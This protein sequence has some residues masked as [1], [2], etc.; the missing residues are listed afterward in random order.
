MH[1]IPDPVSVNWK[2]FTPPSQRKRNMANK[3][4]PK[5]PQSTDSSDS[6]ES[7]SSDSEAEPEAKASGTTPA[8]LLKPTQVGADL[9]PPPGKQVPFGPPGPVLI[10]PGVSELEKE[11]GSVV[12][13]PTASTSADVVEALVAGPVDTSVTT[14]SPAPPTDTAPVTT[15]GS[16][17]VP[18]AGDEASDAVVSGDQ[19]GIAVPDQTEA[20]QATDPDSTSAEA[21]E[22]TPTDLTN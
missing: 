15:E 21:N 11:A 17:P 9:K 22:S 1:S 16:L 18:V 20:L 13:E 4:R 6:S 5:K 2:P 8:G 19:V 12:V 10:D 14:E 3:G 7:L